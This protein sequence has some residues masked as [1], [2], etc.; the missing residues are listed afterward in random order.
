MNT[1]NEILKISEELVINKGISNFK[2]RDVAEGL[3]ISKPAIYKHFNSKS[4]LLQ[5]LSFEWINNVLT[6]LWNYD[7]QDNESISTNLKAWSE[8][9][10]F[11]KHSAYINNPKMFEI[12]SAYILSDTNLLKY[13]FK[14]LC[15]NLMEKMD[16]KKEDADNIIISIMAFNEPFLESLWDNDINIQ[17][18]LFWNFI[19]PSIQKIK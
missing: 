9:L 1:K 14:T 18:G 8:I 19:H 11:S 4:H 17:F 15:N 7:Y 6:D 5:Y 12:Y 10:I 2:L 16:I 13:H 3:N